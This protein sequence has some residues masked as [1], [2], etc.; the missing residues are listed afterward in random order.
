MIKNIFILLVAVNCMGQLNT[1]VG[2]A[3]DELQSDKVNCAK[4]SH[5]PLYFD[6]CNKEAKKVFDKAVDLAVDNFFVCD[7]E[8][9]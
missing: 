8:W 5:L 4:F 2:R 7:P 6:R 9:Y 3:N 1:Q